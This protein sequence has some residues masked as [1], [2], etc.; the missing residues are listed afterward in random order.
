MEAAARYPTWVPHVRVMASRVKATNRD[1]ARIQYPTR[2]ADGI[3]FFGV[4]VM[5]E[6]VKGENV[7]ITWDHQATAFGEVGLTIPDTSEHAR[8]VRGSLAPHGKSRDGREPYSWLNSAESQRSLAF[9]VNFLVNLS[10]DGVLHM[11]FGM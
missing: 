2:L 5:N 7:E 10:W 1:A 8:A 6:T 3:S 4:L 9:S 11:L